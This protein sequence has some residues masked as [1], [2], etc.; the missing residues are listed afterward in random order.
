MGS[1]LP[2]Y[3]SVPHH[4]QQGGRGVGDVPPR[5]RSPGSGHIGW[6]GDR[7]TDRIGSDRIAACSKSPGSG[8]IGWHDYQNDIWLRKR[9]R[10]IVRPH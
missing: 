5:G 7:M 4:H 6:H 10:G 8:H 1:G 3:H 9:D 2:S